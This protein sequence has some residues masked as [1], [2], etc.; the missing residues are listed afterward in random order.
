MIAEKVVNGKFRKGVLADS[1]HKLSTSDNDNQDRNNQQSVGLSYKSYYKQKVTK[2]LD[3][4]VITTESSDA[5]YIE[6]ADGGNWARIAKKRIDPYTTEDE[7][8]YLN[9]KKRGAI[10]RFSHMARKR[11]LTDV[12]KNNMSKVNPHSVIFMTLTA[13]GS[14]WREISGKRWSE[15]LNNFLTQLRKKYGKDNL[16]GYWRLEF[17]KKR[18]APHWHIVTYNIPYIEHTWVSRVWA[19]ICKENLTHEQYM[20]HL[21]AGTQVERAKNWGALKDYF[22]KTMAYVAKEQEDIKPDGSD[23]G[24]YDYIKT[25]GKHWGK[26]GVKALHSLRDIV[27]F[28]FDCPEHYYR[29]RRIVRNYIV[30]CKRNKRNRLIRQGKQVPNALSNKMMKMLSRIFSRNN[31]QTNQIMASNDVIKKILSFLGYDIDEFEDGKRVVDEKKSTFKMAL[32]I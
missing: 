18:G 25:F 12:S 10:T 19:G 28:K 13:P 6:I 20:N 9:R 4:D 1:P 31:H 7:T 24:I 21:S 23:Q 3:Y 30:G 8:K 14:G 32:S 16:C 2:S 27:A 15:R 11:M 17:Q 22:S 29:M 5:Y 26:I